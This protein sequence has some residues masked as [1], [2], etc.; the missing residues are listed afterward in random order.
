LK[1]SLNKTEVVEYTKKLGIEN[2]DTDC[3][4]E[5]RRHVKNVK[6]RNIFFRLI[7]KDFFTRE[8]MLKFKMVN[9]SDCERCGLEETTK[10]LLWD[11]RDTRMMWESYNN[12]LSEGGLSQ[13]SV[14]NYNDVYKFNCTGAVSTVKLKLINELI[15]I[16]RP[17]YM[18]IDKV[19]N[20]IRNLYNTEKY[21]AI[22]NKNDV[23]HNKRWNGIL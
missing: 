15:Q 20:I 9:D 3:I 21:I 2:F 22:K 19:K 14:E 11:C 8:R 6:L 5:T 10:H 18:N 13:F 16:N 4:I 7:N 23:K 1:L 12:I 17:R